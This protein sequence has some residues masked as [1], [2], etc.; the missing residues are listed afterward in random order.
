MKGVPPEIDDLMWRL[1]EENSPVAQAEFESR[2]ARYGPELTRRIRMVAQLRE[3][4]KPVT[5]RPAF[6]PRPSRV[7][8]VSGGAIFAAVSLAVLAAGAVA[9]VV[10]SGGEPPRV[11]VEPS[12]RPQPAT[13]AAPPLK[14]ATPPANEEPKP[15]PIPE[16][17]IKPEPQPTYEKPHDVRIE[18]TALTT[19]IDLV[20]KGGGL[21]VTIA[22][23]FADR[24]VTLDYRG[25]TPV[26]TLKAMGQEYSFT[27]VEEEEGKV[28]VIPVR[29]A[30][31]DRRIS[32]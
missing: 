20:A 3:A 10:A 21:Q 32:G 18:D 15:L 22:P 28:L 16:E 5:H 2:H 9:Y 7:A 1:A 6:T 27:V 14:D 23:G 30:A 12:I 25:L 24:K 29:E 19:A 31:T 17:A 8:P 13:V 26:D 4:G 11:A